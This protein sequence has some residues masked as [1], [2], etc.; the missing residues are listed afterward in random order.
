[1]EMHPVIFDKICKR[2]GTPVVDLFASRLNA[3]LDTYFSWKPDPG[4]TAVDAFTEDWSEHN[5]YA[6]PPF[7][8]IGRV[9][10]KVENDNAQGIIVVPYWPT[11]HWFSKFTRMCTQIP[12]ILFSRDAQPTIKHPWREEQ[13][14]PTMRLLAAPI[15]AQ[16]LRAWASPQLPET[17]YWRHGAQA[18]IDNTPH[19]SNSGV[20][21]VM[22][23]TL[24]H[25]HPI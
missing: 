12:C 23:G 19:I 24:I 20:V 9:L 3:K 7:N 1:M 13:N 21:F 25:C 8:M 18:H 15:S 11:Q 5:F 6:F 17:F 10:R 4:A 16:H 2:W 22:N 14:L